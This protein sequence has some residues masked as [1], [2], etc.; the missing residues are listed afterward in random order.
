MKLTT[1]ERFFA[2]TKTSTTYSWDG[3]ACLEWT[4]YCDED[5]Y[6]TFYYQGKKKLAHRIAMVLAGVELGDLQVLHRCDNPPCVNSDH[7]FLGTNAEN[8]ADRDEKGRGNQPRGERHGSRTKPE[9]LARG[10]RNGSTKQPTPENI[11]IKTKIF[12]LQAN[13]MTQRK[14]AEEVGFSVQLINCILSGNRWAHVP[15]GSRAI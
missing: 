9:R 11:A 3:T 8:M 5:G 1:E 15:H 13:G 14:V 4:A 7:L 10:L 2:K 12:A 6:G